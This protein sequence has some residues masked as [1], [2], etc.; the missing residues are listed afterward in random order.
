MGRDR[1]STQR[2]NNGRCEKDT[3]M[4]GFSRVHFAFNPYD[5]DLHN[6]LF[7]ASKICESF[8]SWVCYGGGFLGV[9]RDPSLP[10]I[11]GCGNYKP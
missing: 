2:Q 8:V 11:R 7:R 9:L 3:T 4:R 1:Q 5:G 6:M 10:G